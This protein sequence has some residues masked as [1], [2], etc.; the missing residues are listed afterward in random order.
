MKK[1]WAHM[2]VVTSIVQILGFEAKESAHS[3]E[4][5]VV[6]EAL[7]LEGAEELPGVDHEDASAWDQLW[8]NGGESAYRCLDGFRLEV[9]NR[10]KSQKSE[11]LL[12]SN[13]T[14]SISPR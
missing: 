7:S 6:H 14:Y 10:Q 1:E 5:A 12:R 9:S 8:Y 4:L 13:G 2:S 11:L 3:L